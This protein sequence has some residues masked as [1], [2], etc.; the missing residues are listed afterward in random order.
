VVL[1]SPTD[2]HRVGTIR[3]EAMPKPLS[4]KK[5]KRRAE[6]YA[7]SPDTPDRFIS[8]DEA[9]WRRGVSLDAFRTAQRKT[10]KP[11]RYR[12]TENRNGYR[13]SEVMQP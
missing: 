4:I 13:L 8:E 5:A 10:G 7:H 1:F 6:L 3:E 2:T 11:Q 9:A 12:M